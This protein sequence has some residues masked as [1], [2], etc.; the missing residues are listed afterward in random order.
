M[1][2]IIYYGGEVGFYCGLPAKIVEDLQKV[3]PT[4]FVGV[5][6]IWNRFYDRIQSQI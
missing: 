5:P 4:F 2:G 3:R 1:A 6:R